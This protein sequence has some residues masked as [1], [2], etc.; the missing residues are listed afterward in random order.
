MKG[1]KW[2]EFEDSSADL[3]AEGTSELKIK[4]IIAAMNSKQLDDINLYCQNILEDE[5]AYNIFG[6]RYDI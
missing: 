2:I 5:F 1:Y 3:L 4:E 6:E